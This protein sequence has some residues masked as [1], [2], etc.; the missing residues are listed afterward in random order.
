MGVCNTVTA[1]KDVAREERLS[2]SRRRHS[3]IP[4]SRKQVRWADEERSDTKPLLIIAI[5]AL[6]GLFALL[7]VLSRW[8]LLWTPSPNSLE[9][10]SSIVASSSI[11]PDMGQDGQRMVPLNG[12]EIRDVDMVTITRS[13]RN[14]A[15]PHA[16]ARAWA[17]ALRNRQ[18]SSS[19]TSATSSA[20]AT[21]TA[22]P[23][24]NPLRVFQVDVPLLGPSGSI[25]GAGTPAGFTGIQTTMSTETSGNMTSSTTSTCEVTLALNTFANSFDSPFVGTYMPPACL[26]SSNANTVMMNLTVQSQGTQFDRL[27]IV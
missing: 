26:G 27:F 24:F 10:S 13:S 8:G 2:A 23:P 22:L 9:V 7:A 15:H 20:S 12:H 18:A 16:G 17:Q 21:A 25:V 1:D 3:S 6:N 4:A 19:L 11:P 5:F 14:D